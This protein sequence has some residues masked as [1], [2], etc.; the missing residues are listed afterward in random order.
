MLMY[1]TKYLEIKKLNPY[2]AQNTIYLYTQNIF[3]NQKYLFFQ[4]QK[5]SIICQD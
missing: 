3:G 1:E 4:Q 5:Y 2:I